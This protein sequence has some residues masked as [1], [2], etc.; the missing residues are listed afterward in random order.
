MNNKTIV[1]LEIHAQL[2]SKTKAFCTCL[3]DNNLE[4]NTATCPGCLGMPGA[5]PRINKEV[6]ILA[7]KAGL[8]FNCKINNESTFERKKYFYPDL[9]KGYQITQSEIPICSDG[10]IE[11]DD[12]NGNIKK[13]NIER[14]QIEEDTGKSL[15]SND[16]FVYMD[17]NRSGA[18]L[19]EIITKPDINSAK[20]AKI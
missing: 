16:G 10:Y 5:L 1:G 9:P 18:P 17:Y 12:I 8:A 4:P 7:I 6:V 14:I 20:E 19:I 13:I 2:N 3:N 11:V 15:H